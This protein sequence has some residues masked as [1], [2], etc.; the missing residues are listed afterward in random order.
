[1]L[2]PASQPASPTLPTSGLRAARQ[3]NTP[4]PSQH[5]SG[6]QTLG[7]PGPLLSPVMEGKTRALGTTREPLHALWSGAG[8]GHRY[9][10]HHCLFFTKET[11]RAGGL[12]LQVGS[13]P[14]LLVLVQV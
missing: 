7:L 12:P 10:D 5:P 2:T 6:S 3:G 9:T 11:H 13:V 14:F 8:L 4:P 1:M